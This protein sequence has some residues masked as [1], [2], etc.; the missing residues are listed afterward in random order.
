[1]FSR[2]S[3]STLHAAR[4]VSWWSQPSAQCAWSR[5]RS[6]PPWAAAPGFLF[7]RQ[8]PGGPLGDLGQHL[9]GAALPALLF[10]R[11][12]WHPEG[13]WPPTTATR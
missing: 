8:Q 12:R 9:V 7:G 13:A 1:M 3:L 11:R 4:P 2:S 5:S 10:P 6:T